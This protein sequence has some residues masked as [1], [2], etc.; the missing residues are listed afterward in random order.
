MNPDYRYLGEESRHHRWN[1]PGSPVISTFTNG[2]PLL[3]PLRESRVQKARLNGTLRSSRQGRFLKVFEIG[4]RLVDPWRQEQITNL[5]LWSKV[6]PEHIIAK[7]LGKERLEVRSKSHELGVVLNPLVDGWTVRQLSN[8][9]GLPEKTI[10]FWID[11]GALK[12]MPERQSH[13]RRQVARNG[14]VSFV[15]YQRYRSKVLS[16]VDP[17]VLDWIAGF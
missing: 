10:A 4:D 1:L 3:L 16:R 12:T 13:G 2:K 6:F 9:L 14:L 5:I 8:L 17:D 11:A 15:L 7:K